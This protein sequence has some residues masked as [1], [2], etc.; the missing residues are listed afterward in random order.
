MNIQSYNVMI[1]QWKIKLEKG[2]L[3]GIIFDGQGYVYL[4]DDSRVLKYK[5][6]LLGL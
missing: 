2:A 5:K 6:K 1:V 3:E 4:A